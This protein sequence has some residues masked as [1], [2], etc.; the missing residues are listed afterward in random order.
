MSSWNRFKDGDDNDA[1][2]TSF[3]PPYSP[4]FNAFR[5]PR[6]SGIKTDIRTVPPSLSQYPEDLYN[7]LKVEFN[8]ALIYNF[9]WRNKA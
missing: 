1:R 6:P 8:K 2:Q 4:F 7:A 3:T 9:N 5:T